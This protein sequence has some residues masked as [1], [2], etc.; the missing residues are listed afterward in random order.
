MEAIMRTNTTKLMDLQEQVIAKAKEVI[1]KQQEKIDALEKQV[2][3]LQER[4]A[5]YESKSEETVEEI[6]PERTVRDEIFINHLESICRIAGIKNHLEDMYDLPISAI[7]RDDLARIIMMKEF[8]PMG[9]SLVKWEEDDAVEYYKDIFRELMGDFNS[10]I[11]TVR[12][13]LGTSK[14]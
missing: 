2:A 3:E 7:T 10:L 9:F 12:E 6:E 5:M 1:D 14:R 11:Y 13:S 8:L 4:L